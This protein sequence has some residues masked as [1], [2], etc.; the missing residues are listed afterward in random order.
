MSEHACNL[1]FGMGNRVLV[2]RRGAVLSL[3]AVG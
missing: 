3:G 1:K 2:R